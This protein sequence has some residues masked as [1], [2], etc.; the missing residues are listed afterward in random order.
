MALTAQYEPGRGSDC[1]YA[2]H[3][4]SAHAQPDRDASTDSTASD[5]SGNGGSPAACKESELALKI[6]Y[7]RYLPCM[8]AVIIA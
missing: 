2:D 4:A 7:N 3:Q 5:V 1:R 6:P 8:M